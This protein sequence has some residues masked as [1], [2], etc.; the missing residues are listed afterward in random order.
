MSL[1][2]DFDKE[3]KALATAAAHG[4][5][6]WDGS[7]ALAMEMTHD[8]DQRQLRL[9]DL[10]C[11]VEKQK[12]EDTIGVW[13][14]E[15][16]EV[17]K[18]ITDYRTVSRFWPKDIRDEVLDELPRLNYSLLKLAANRFPN[19]DEALPFLVECASNEWSVERARVT[20]NKRMGKRVP[21]E[22]FIPASLVEIVSLD[23][24]T[25]TMTVKFI[26]GT[27]PMHLSTGVRGKLVMTAAGE[28]VEVQA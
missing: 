18:T 5:D 24:R 4:E 9:G 2:E 13:A 7:K 12:G 3:Y 23:P 27:F 22:K 20:L 19:R 16:G 21:A 6:I 10:A 25:L 17:R 14:T 1:S 8:L 15:I 28:L 11:L 26:G